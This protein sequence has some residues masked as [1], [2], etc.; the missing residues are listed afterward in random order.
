MEALF[1]SLIL[2]YQ[3]Y[4][5]KINEMLAH[6]AIRSSVLELHSKKQS[7]EESWTSRTRPLPGDVSSGTRLRVATTT[8]DKGEFSIK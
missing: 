4:E 3:C 7:R 6:A 5:I 8:N 1:N 2:T